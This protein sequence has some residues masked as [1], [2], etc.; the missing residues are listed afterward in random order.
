MLTPEAFNALLKTLEEPP[1]HVKFIFATTAAGKVPATVLSRCQRFDFRRIE[2][3]T[4]VE[5]LGRIASAERVRIDEPAL[6]AIARASDGSL[7]DGE[8]ILEQL[9]SFAAGAI[10]EQDVTELLGAVESSALLE[11]AQAIL[12]QNVPT[13]L[14][15][16]AG[17]AEAGRDAPSI[18][19]GLLRHV[20][21]LLVLR[22][23]QEAA[24]RDELL[25]RLVDEPAD[26]LA[27]LQQQA[28]RST[29]QELLMFLQVLTACYEMVRRS[30][31]AQA[32]LELAVIKLCTREA[33]QSL[34]E[35]SR[36]LERL[37]PPASHGPA[38][39]RPALAEARASEPS[40]TA[41]PAPPLDVREDADR[42][43]HP[44]PVPE[45]LMAV[46]PVFLERLG[47]QKMSLAA[48]L[49]HAK[50]LQ[51]DGGTL[52]IGLAG[53]SLHHEVLSLTD[54]R[55][56][57]DR[58]LT[59]LCQT[60]VTAQYVTLPDTAPPPPAAEAPAS[61]PPIVQ[62]IVNLFNATVVN[63]PPRAA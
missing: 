1:A 5:A 17:Q 59:E 63:R 40:R 15:T 11:L 9:A 12:D 31:M 54:N 41:I 3:A 50:P 28:E 53:F 23:T 46:W 32:I 45:A 19:G 35:I 58:L 20:R 6:Y 25:P 16:L 33:W 61:A 38:A 2:A 30:P 18:L 60:A 29:T 36:R 51:L 26:R 22:S 48:Y 62:D 14:A 27:R 55:R 52:T 43:A 7:R 39:S 44:A 13:A 8:V 49:M 34:D 24:S 57:I 56:L 10:G 47:A 21:N 42:S 4:M 37:G